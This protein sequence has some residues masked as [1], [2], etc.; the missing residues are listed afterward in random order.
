MVVELVVVVVLVL[1]FHTIRP[2]GIPSQ[3]TGPPETSEA[4][5][6]DSMVMDTAAGSSEAKS[7]SVLATTCAL[8][9]TMIMVLTPSGYV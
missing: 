5:R 3:I 8:G 6:F 1:S 7:T 2:K 9:N 4:A